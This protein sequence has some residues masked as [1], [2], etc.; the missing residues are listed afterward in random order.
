MIRS[1]IS[2]WSRFQVP[3]IGA[4]YSRSSPW[5][6]LFAGQAI[7]WHESRPEAALDERSCGWR[8]LLETLNSGKAQGINDSRDWSI[9]RGLGGYFPVP[10]EVKFS[11]GAVLS[12]ATSKCIRAY[13]AEERCFSAH[14]FRRATMGS[15]PA[16]RCAGTTDARRAAEASTSTATMSMIGFHGV[17]P[18]N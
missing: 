4:D 13:G 10:L 1:V 11:P 17:T 15:T 14:S 9:F 5:K 18:N 2:G 16:A 12:S 6:S 3:N 7:G 8:C